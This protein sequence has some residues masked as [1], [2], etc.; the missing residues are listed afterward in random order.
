MAST[1]SLALQVLCPGAVFAEAGAMLGS[2]STV[3]LVEFFKPAAS[4]SGATKIHMPQ[5][6]RVTWSC[7]RTH[8]KAKFCM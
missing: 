5:Q 1:Q 3:Q 6:A 8:D 2:G 4:R 7:G